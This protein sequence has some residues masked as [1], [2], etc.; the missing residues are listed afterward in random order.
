MNRRIIASFLILSLLVTGL[1]IAA[2]SPVATAPTAVPTYSLSVDVS[3]LGAGS[4]TPPGGNWD[5][6]LKVTLN[7]IPNQGYTFDYWEG[8]ASSSSQSIDIVMSSNKNVIAH[9]KPATLESSKEED[10]KDELYN[11]Q[12]AVLA[13]MADAQ[14]SSIPGGT[15]SASS[16]VAINATITVGDYI[17]GGIANIHGTYTV[18]PTGSVTQTTYP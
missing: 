2:C 14:V 17:V 8:A 18:A 11:I 5:S 13:G 12:T 9:F 3:P 15:L 1:F 10:A 7:A 4:V 6:G 16:N